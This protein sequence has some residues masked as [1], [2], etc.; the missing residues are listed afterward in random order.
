VSPSQVE[1]LSATGLIDARLPGR[2]WSSGRD[3]HAA[4]GRVERPE[5][6][7]GHPAEVIAFL[8]FVGGDLGGGIGRLR[9]RGCA[10]VGTVTSSR[11]PARRY[12]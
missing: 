4:R 11:T 5:G 8:T 2:I 7:G 3:L 6:G 10:L 1:P 9:L 12:G